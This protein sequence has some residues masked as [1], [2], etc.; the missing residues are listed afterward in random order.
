ML[1]TLIATFGVSAIL[2]GVMAALSMIER[3]LAPGARR[4]PT[5]VG[6]SARRLAAAPISVR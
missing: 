3:R 5:R 4:P 1:V 6:H 2:V